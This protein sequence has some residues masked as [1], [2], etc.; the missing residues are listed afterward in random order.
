MFF[1]KATLLFA[2]LLACPTAAFVSPTTASTRCCHHHQFHATLAPEETLNV[3]NDQRNAMLETIKAVSSEAKAY[4]QD[5]GLTDTEAAIYAY[6]S[7]IRNAKEVALGLKGEPFVL[8]R[9][10]LLEALGMDNAF[11]HFF[12][13]EDFKKATEDDFLD[14]VRGS[15]DNKKPWKVS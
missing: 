8:R 12:T 9:E 15:M 10:E 4:A 2:A 7:A 13:M 11:D 14:A 3:S 1:Q 5:F 6:F